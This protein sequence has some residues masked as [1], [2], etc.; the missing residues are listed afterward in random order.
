MLPVM[1]F[2]ARPNGF[3]EFINR[4][5][6][7]VTGYR[8]EDLI[9]D[10]W[11]SIVHAEDVDRVSAG[12]QHAADAERVQVECRLRKADGGSI[13]V[14]LC[15]GLLRSKS[16]QP[17]GWYGTATDIDELKYVEESLRQRELM[18]ADSERRFRMLAEAIPII[19]WTADATGWMDWYNRQWHAFTALTHEE[20]AGW[21]WQAAHHP[22]DLLDFM[23]R[24]P[25]SIATGEPFEMEHRLRRHDGVFHWHLT[26]AHPMRDGMGKIVRW[27]GSTVDIESQK[28]A[29]ERAKLIAE[30]LQDIFLPK[31]LPQGPA[32]R[33]DAVYVAAE[34]DALVGGDWYDALELP[35][36]RILFSIGDV[37]GHGLPA[38]VLA[39]MLRQAISTLAFGIDDPAEILRRANAILEHREPEAI[40]T[41]LVGFVDRSHAGLSY[42]SA[43]HPPPLI[44]VRRDR[45]AVALP[46]GGAPLGSGLGGDYATHRVSLR[47]NAVVALYT[48]GVVEFSRDIAAAER[49]LREALSR[50][51]GDTRVDSPA[52]AIHQS[53]R[54]EV[55]GRDD[56]ALLLMQFSK[57]DPAHIGSHSA[58]LEKTWRF[59]SSDARVAQTTRHEIMSYLRGMTAAGDEAFASELI[60]G[61]IIAN[62][63]EHAPGLVEIHVDWSSEKPVL[64]VRDSGPGL[65]SLLTELPSDQLSESGRGLFL[66]RLLADRLSVRRGFEQGT[67]LRATLPLRKRRFRLADALART[68]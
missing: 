52:Y 21:G 25:H 27:Y 5:W 24:W 63:V 48:D 41:T 22:D 36:G 46:A 68:D 15:A 40:A 43:G 30:T 33:M 4:H 35:D 6:S 23:R 67:E 49:K 56:A 16:G 61:E 55:Q 9:G 60:V 17:L 44:A 20:S 19:C 26:R 3:F 13:W 54:G 32:L 12:W 47:K 37:V 1:M 7:E 2:T 58:K 10:N 65:K 14:A 34:K 51:V 45:P 18:L 57:V 59:H 39:G 64:T 11:L 8:W 42:A 66:V 29:L 28:A 62:T 38:S 31:K 53:V 50:L